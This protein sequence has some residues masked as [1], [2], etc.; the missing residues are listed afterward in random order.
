MRVRPP[1][2]PPNNHPNLMRL[3]IMSTQEPPIP[4]FGTRWKIRNSTITVTVML[5]LDSDEISDPWVVY[6]KESNGAVHAEYVS[7]WHHRFFPV[8]AG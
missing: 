5:I 3:P 1:S 4:K 2:L 7:S 6:K 8:Q